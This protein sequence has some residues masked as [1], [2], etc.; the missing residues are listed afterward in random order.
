M[1]SRIISVL[2]PVCV[3]ATIS[4]A[5]L[6][7]LCLWGLEIVSWDVFWKLF[8]TYVALMLT[9]TLICYIDDPKHLTGK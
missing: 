9:S 8:F 2:R 1:I 3:A 5:G 7:V 6:L 4:M